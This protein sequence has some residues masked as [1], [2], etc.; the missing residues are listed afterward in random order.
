MKNKQK[1]KTKNIYKNR[2]QKQRNKT[3]FL[4]SDYSTFALDE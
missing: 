2:K 3:L 1:A 4:K